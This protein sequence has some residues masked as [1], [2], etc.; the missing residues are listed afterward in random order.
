MSNGQAPQMK[1]MGNYEGPGKYPFSSRK[2]MV[3][4]ILSRAVT[5]KG[6]GR[7]KVELVNKWCFLT[8]RIRDFPETGDFIS[9][10]I[11][12]QGNITRICVFN[13]LIR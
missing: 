1:R 2:S 3:T 8:S 7:R 6:G 5:E 12:G 13:N 4:V 10:M 9:V 11:Y